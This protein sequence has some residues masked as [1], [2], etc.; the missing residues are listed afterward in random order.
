L[1]FVP[2]LLATLA[3]WG[4]GQAN[5]VCAPRPLPGNYIETTLINNLRLA[6]IL[7]FGGFVLAIPTVAELV[8]NGLV[9]GSAVSG[10]LKKPLILAAGLL[11]HGGFEIA[12][13]II[14]ASVGF[15][16]TR[17]EIDLIRGRDSRIDVKSIGRVALTVVILLVLAAL[18]ETFITPPLLTSGC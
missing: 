4:V 2:L 10:L 15:R 16:L 11:P 13:Y 6:L 12:S 17:L 8:F 18:I 3:G 5:P 14:A 1:F 7:S 9:L